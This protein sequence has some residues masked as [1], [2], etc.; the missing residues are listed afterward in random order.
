MGIADTCL[1]ECVQDPLTV[2]GSANT[3]YHS[4]SC[5][6][7]LLLS[8]HV[9]HSIDL[10]LKTFLTQTSI[11]ATDAPCE[12]AIS[13][14]NVL[15]GTPA[16]IAVHNSECSQIESWS[17]FVEQVPATSMIVVAVVVADAPCER[18]LN[19]N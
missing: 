4:P 2:T 18:T 11:A 12:R 10:L 9:V 1:T 14:G 7:S 3:D 16:T 6:Y 15:H 8:Q 17:H 19:P 5:K 13:L